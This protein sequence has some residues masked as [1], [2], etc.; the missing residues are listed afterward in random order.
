MKIVN[1]RKNAKGLSPIIIIIILA[2]VGIGGFI[3]YN[4]SKIS[5]Q[6]LNNAE[7]TTSNQTYPQA[8]DNSEKVE[9]IEGKTYTFY[10]PKN[11]IKTDE[12]VGNKAT[13]ITYQSPNRT[14]DKE[15][16]RFFIEPLYSRNDTPT[17]E[18]CTAS[19]QFFVR[20]VKNITVAEAK[21]VDYIKS[22]GCEFSYVDTSVE[23]RLIA[24]EKKLWFK[25]GDDINVYGISFFYL[26]ILTQPEKETID[27]AVDKFALK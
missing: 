17:T 12:K 22:H 26:N 6:S 20:G 21:P 7:P 24:R 9:K 15:G 14:N 13:V 5:Q 8:Q 1:Y 25:E 18:F 16:M 23:N 2:V 27:Y 4:N 10:I 11:Y 19:L 3:L